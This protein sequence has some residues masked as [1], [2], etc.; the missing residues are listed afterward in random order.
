M[1]ELTVQPVEPVEPRA[2]RSPVEMAIDRVWRFFCSV[3]AAIS[4]IAFL[5]LLVLI[6]TLRGSEVPEWIA[7]ALPFTRPLVDRWYA[8]EVFRSLPFVAICTLIA[9]AIAICTVN[10]A[11]GIWKTIAHPTVRTSHGFLRSAEPSARIAAGAAPD[12]LIDDLSGLLRRRRYRVLT[13]R[14][15]E[16]IHLYADKHRWAKLG[17]FPFHLALILVMVGGIVGARF[18]FR[19]QE[20][21]IAEGETRS[22]GHGTGLALTLERFTDTYNLDGSARE[23]RSELVLLDDGEAVKREGITVNNPLTYRTLSIYQASFG[24]TVILRVSDGEGMILFEGPVDMGIYRSTVNPDAPAGMLPI[25][26]AG[27]TLNIIAPDE[28]PWNAP[29]MDQLDLQ[30]GQVYLQARPVDT[31]SGQQP[32]AA[33]ATQGQVANLGAIQVEFVR[34]GRFALLQI[35]SNP[36]IPIF[37][38]AALLLVGGLAVTFYFPHRRVRGIVGAVPVGSV[39]HLAPLARRDW[40]GQRDFG[41]LLDD[42]RERLNLRPE[43]LSAP[44]STGSDAGEPGAPR[45]RRGRAAP[46]AGPAD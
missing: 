18:G 21:I 33:I 34:E 36:G 4:E 27:V 19:D 5:A 9:V 11:P 28:N 15:G 12:A 3:R 45:S 44:A 42:V 32:T 17:T 20:F 35:A 6:G 1:A 31:A 43:V 16:E 23:Y 13:E 14:R 24:Q 22:I 25:P 29:E 8:W 30:S 2:G 40:S 7:D 10:R 26:Q 41:R 46:T 37:F 38:V 39:A